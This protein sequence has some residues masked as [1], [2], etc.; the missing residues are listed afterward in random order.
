VA[1]KLA[2]ELVAREPFGEIETLAADCFRQLVQTPYIAIRINDTIYEDSKQ[3]L[4]D[5][6]KSR[7]F[8]GRLA[9]M[10]DAERAPGDCRIEWSDGGVV[11]DH[12]AIDAAIAEVVARYIAARTA[13]VQ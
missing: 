11:R 1:R 2:P 6:A 8:E 9:V 3:K 12:A 7:G 4:E 13:E 10:S 5:I